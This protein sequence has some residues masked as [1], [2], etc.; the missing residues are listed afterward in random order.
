[1]EDL[2]EGTTPDSRTIEERQAEA[3]AQA[4]EDKKTNREL[5]EN[6]GK[7]PQFLGEVVKSK[8]EELKEEINENE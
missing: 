8:E 6:K 7:E 1:M 2:N 5:K 4:A 3:K